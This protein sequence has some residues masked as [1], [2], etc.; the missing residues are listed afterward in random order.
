VPIIVHWSSQRPVLSFLSKHTSSQ[1]PPTLNAG[2]QQHAC[3]F[4]HSPHPRCGFHPAILRLPSGT[5]AAR[6]RLPEAH[7]PC[8]SV[9]LRRL[10]HLKRLYLNSRSLRCT[11]TA[12]PCFAHQ[13]ASVSND[14]FREGKNAPKGNCVTPGMDN[15][16]GWCYVMSQQALN[17]LQTHR[18]ILVST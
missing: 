5:T 2:H 6:R 9:C 15:T 13:C 1:N 3:F 16:P 7:R 4:Y 18:R 10:S 17:T 12:V 14:G 11:G 8:Q